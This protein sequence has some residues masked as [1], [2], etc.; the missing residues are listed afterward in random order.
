[1]ASNSNLSVSSSSNSS[2]TASVLGAPKAPPRSGLRYTNYLG[3][4]KTMATHTCDAKR[5]INGPVVV[6]A[7]PTREEPRTEMESC[8]ERAEVLDMDWMI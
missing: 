6:F 4:V 3:Q 7:E 2:D 8:W 1:M 5:W